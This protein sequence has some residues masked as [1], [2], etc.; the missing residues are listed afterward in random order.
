MD[1]KLPDGVKAEVKGDTLIVTGKLGSNTR[2]YNNVLLELS[3]GNG[4]VTIKP[5]KAK[6]LAYKAQIS[7]KS[8]AK[9][10]NN[11]IEG[12]SKHYERNMKT[13]YAHFPI[14][15]E[16]KDNVVRIN[17]II[18]ERVPRLS[19]IVGSTKVEVKGQNVRI[20]GTSLDDV[21]QTAA[22]IRTACVMRKK[23]TR[24]FQDGLYFEV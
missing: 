8:L 11:D 23:D 13:V 9:E 3:V 6:K 2:R 15:V 20:Y 16:V 10:I 12:V 14:N 18:G 17:N 1:V 21:T 7:E 22:N 24:V 4:A 5:T 19:K